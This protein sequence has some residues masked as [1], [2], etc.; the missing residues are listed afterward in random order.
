MVSYRGMAESRLEEGE[1]VGAREYVDRVNGVSWPEGF[2]E[3]YLRCAPG[4]TLWLITPPP[5]GWPPG[6][7]H[8]YDPQNKTP[9]RSKKSKK[10]APP[11]VRPS[12]IL[13]GGNKK[14]LSNWKNPPKC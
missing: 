14:N 4:S 13:G 8:D 9:F 2:G 3:H 10:H 6:P 11:K 7:N 5:G 1:M 12:G